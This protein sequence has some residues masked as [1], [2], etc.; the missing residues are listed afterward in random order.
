M[1]NNA[2]EQTDWS[3]PTI[4]DDNW[5]SVVEKQLE[6]LNW[7]EIREDVETFLEN[8]EEREMLTY[9]NLSSVL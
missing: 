5:Q 6:T 1:L 4:A 3:G 8:P 7:K 9:E 2:L